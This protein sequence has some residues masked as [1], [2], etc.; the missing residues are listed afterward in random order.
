MPVA[1]KVLGQ[2]AT[3]AT[4]E[5]T[6]Y[7]V[8]SATQVVVSS[9]VV[10]NRGT[11]SATY[12][13]A[14][15]PNGAAISNEHYLAHDVTVAANDSVPLTLGITCDASDVF[16]VRASTANLTFQIFGSEITS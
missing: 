7:T 1:Y 11:T 8:P 9:V 5:T 10:C 14:L 13:I 4:T 6:L 16:T 2:V 3:A 15:R 12:R